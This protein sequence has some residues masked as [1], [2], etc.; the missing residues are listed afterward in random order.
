MLVEPWCASHPKAQRALCCAYGLFSNATA[1][2]YEYSRPIQV[3]MPPLRCRSSFPT[4]LHVI[5]GSAMADAEGETD[6][7]RPVLFESCEGIFLGMR[8]SCHSAVL[9]PS[10]ASGKYRLMIWT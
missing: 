10:Q 5:W 4:P 9:A 6:E 3:A 1:A 2:H 7:M 8:P